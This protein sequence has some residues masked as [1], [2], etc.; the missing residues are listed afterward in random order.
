MGV[1]NAR[2]WGPMVEWLCSEEMAE[3]LT[4]ASWA[5]LVEHAGLDPLTQAAVTNE[6]LAH[7]YGVLGRFFLKHT[8]A[9]L[10]E[11]A[12]RRGI[13]LFPVHTVR[14]LLEH[15]Q[16]LAR[17]FFQLMEHPELDETLCYPGAPYQLSETPWQLRRRAPL[18]GEH[19]AA[20]YSGELGLSRA[21]L[22]VLLAAGAI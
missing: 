7:V 8:K 9:E 5:I 10:A 12:Q 20:I 19:N 16:L 6:E 18:I 21:E 14:D 1:M 22:A 15:P 17:S 2:E 13:I 4:D 3:D 11:E